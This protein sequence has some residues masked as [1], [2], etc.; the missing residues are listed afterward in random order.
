MSLTS[1]SAGSGNDSIV[2]AGTAITSTL[3]AGAGD[4]LDFDRGGIAAGSI[5]GG[6]W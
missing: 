3:R 6:D 4:D 5:Y 1:V 2:V